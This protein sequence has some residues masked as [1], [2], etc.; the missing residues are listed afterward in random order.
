MH[1]YFLCITECNGE[2]HVGDEI[3]LSS[4]DT[5][6][7]CS[8]RPV[9]E[10][11]TYSGALS[12]QPWNSEDSDDKFLLA[13]NSPVF[14]HPLMKGGGAN[15]KGGVRPAS[16]STFLPTFESESYL[17]SLRSLENLKQQSPSSRRFIPLLQ[18]SSSSVV[19]SECMCLHHRSISSSLPLCSFFVLLCHFSVLIN[20]QL[21]LLIR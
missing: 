3:S 12:C 21:G 20:F 11:Y 17:M 10:Q 16:G 13:S 2:M 5:T 15:S 8:Q 19:E 4:I 9:D 1:V 18:C 6:Y 7:I 14:E